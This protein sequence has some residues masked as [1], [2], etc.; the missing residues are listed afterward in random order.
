VTGRCASSR[1]DVP[2]PSPGGTTMLNL[3]PALPVRRPDLVF[4]PVGDRGRY[5]VKETECF[6]LA[7]GGRCGA[8]PGAQGRIPGRAGPGPGDRADRSGRI[9][10]TTT[11][12]HED[13]EVDL[14][15]A[16]NQCGPGRNAGRTSSFRCP[17]SVARPDAGDGR[18]TA[19]ERVERPR[20]ASRLPSQSRDPGARC[21]NGGLPPGALRR[22]KA[23]EP[24]PVG[25]TTPPASLPEREET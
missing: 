20:P 5:V 24:E 8:Q 14:Y 19:P 6:H 9:W 1:R 16:R 10:L 21:R 3:A 18:G 12:G 23:R 25:S 13:R 2:A 17:G 7:E 15:Q 4:S 22:R 11:R